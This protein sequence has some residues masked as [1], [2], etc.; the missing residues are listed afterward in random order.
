MA[1]PV[2]AA[3]EAAGS[4]GANVVGGLF[5]ANQARKN[6]QYQ[7]RMYY[8]QLEDN[9]KILEDARAYALPSAELQRLK[10][11]NLNPLLYYGQG[12]AMSTI[13]PAQGASS[14]HGAQ[15]QAN[16]QNPFAGFTQNMKAMEMMQAEIDR[17]KAETNKANSESEKTQSETDWQ[18]LENK[19]QF[20]TFNVR[21]AIQHHNADLLVNSLE[22]LRAETFNTWQIGTQTVL[23]M[24]QG[25]EYEIKR[26]DLDKETQGSYIQQGWKS[27]VNDSARVNQ[28][29]KQLALDAIRVTNETRMTNAQVG[30]LQWQL[31]QDKAMFLPRFEGLSLDNKL[32]R[33]D[34][35]LRKATLTEKQVQTFNGMLKNYYLKNTGVETFNSDH[36]NNFGRGLWQGANKPTFQEIYTLPWQK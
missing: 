12:G 25:R 18:K 10:D 34:T 27:L 16:F 13:T 3:V 26:F 8:Q 24:M 21:K 19:F 23:T 11:A 29:W 22:K 2:A 36:L 7:E 30:M 17:I 6:R 32:K 31:L 28:G 20:E 33:W 5:S 1:F 9:K 14:P 35:H 4:L 15:A